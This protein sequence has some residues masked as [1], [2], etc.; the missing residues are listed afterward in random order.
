MTSRLGKEVAE[1]IAQVKDTPGWEVEDLGHRLKIRSPEG[2]LT[3]H[4]RRT[5]GRGINN[6]VSHLKKAGWTPPDK[7]HRAKNTH[8]TPPAPATDPTPTPAQPPEDTTEDTMT[9]A[10]TIV[11]TSPCEHLKGVNEV[12]M[13]DGTVRYQCTECAEPPV[14]T[15]EDARDHRDSAHPNLS[16]AVRRVHKAMRITLMNGDFGPPGAAMPSHRTLAQRYGV[17]PPVIAAALRALGNASLVVAVAREGT[18]VG[19]AVQPTRKQ[20]P[21]PTDL[22]ALP[23]PPDP[24][25]ETTPETPQEPRQATN[26]R[27][28]APTPTPTP[29]S[30]TPTPASPA[31]APTAPP[32]PTAGPPTPTPTPAPTTQE[33]PMP[34]PTPHTPPTRTANY[35][36]GSP[37]DIA[38]RLNGKAPIA[39]TQHD[40]QELLNRAQ[41]Q[42]NRVQEWLNI[43]ATDPAKRQ[44]MEATIETL[45]RENQELSD[46]LSKFEAA[47]A[48][49]RGL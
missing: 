27:P 15:I 35:N 38:A 33:P 2:H 32:A 43:H 12:L 42:I 49:F 17:S 29:A 11:D 6:F 28:E 1:V 16:A 46:K 36:G 13:T 9:A 23:L 19:P 47:A 8:A 3:F 48:L 40:A 39:L 26:S 10:P 34:T 4:P 25:P 7:R 37:G 18:F 5:I 22:P 45:K 41:A 14:E 30:P 21:A 44:E 31:P 24:G 20:L